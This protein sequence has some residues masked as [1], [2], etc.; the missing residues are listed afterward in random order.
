MRP[1]SPIFSNDMFVEFTGV[2]CEP[3]MA[4]IRRWVRDGEVDLSPD[5]DAGP[6]SRT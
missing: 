6:R 2:S 4:A 1:N 5:E 3:A